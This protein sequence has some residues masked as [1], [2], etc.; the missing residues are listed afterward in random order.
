[1]GSS[2]SNEIM[3]P[4]QG[5]GIT[6]V[7]P[8]SKGSTTI[9]PPHMY[10]REH[11]DGNFNPAVAISLDK[12]PT[13]LV[14]GAGMAGVHAAYELAMRGFKVSVI[15][16][17][18]QVGLG[19]T[20]FAYPVVGEKFRPFVFEKFSWK[21]AV[22]SALFG[23]NSPGGLL[24]EDR[25]STL[26][27]NLKCFGTVRKALRCSTEELDSVFK[28]MSDDSISVIKGMAR[29][30]PSL[31]K[32]AVRIPSTD[33]AGGAMRALPVV[34][35]A[36]TTAAKKQK[37]HH[38]V[39]VVDSS[40][41]NWTLIPTEGSSL[42]TAT[43][44]PLPTIHQGERIVVNPLKWTRTL[45]DVCRNELGVEFHMG[46]DLYNIHTKEHRDGYD[47]V[48]EVIGDEHKG[49]KD[50]YL[51]KKVLTADVYVLAA[52]HGLIAA[53]NHVL[54]EMPLIPV[55]GLAVV[56]P[57]PT[58]TTAPTKLLANDLLRSSGGSA[59]T[60]AAGYVSENG[61][62]HAVPFDRPTFTGNPREGPINEVA[63]CGGSIVT[64]TMNS[65]ITESPSTV[66]KSLQ[67][68]VRAG[69]PVEWKDAIL[70]VAG[71][72]ASSASRSNG[73]QVLQYPRVVTP[74]GLPVV[75]RLGP[76]FN[77]F[78][79]GGFHDNACALVP[80]CAKSL[81]EMVTHPSKQ[82]I[83]HPLSLDRYMP[84]NI[85]LKARPPTPTVEEL[86]EE[87]RRNR[88]SLGYYDHF[89]N[90]MNH[91]VSYPVRSA[92]SSTAFALYQSDLFGS[93]FKDWLYFN[94]ITI[95]QEEEV[96][97]GPIEE[98]R[99]YSD[100]K[101]SANTIASP[102][103]SN[104]LYPFTEGHRVLSASREIVDMPL[105]DEEKRQWKRPQQ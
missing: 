63:V 92:V 100:I 35:E 102:T 44:S 41:E 38:D 70:Q 19:S 23:T 86:I 80:S 101:M 71:P 98:Y 93:S 75:S 22:A 72:G 50:N 7:F 60:L 45:A 66:A 31:A 2:H 10:P 49:A 46:T 62:T 103:A 94:F 64:S 77:A 65:L 84:N 96:R 51:H 82:E 83:A 43:D 3:T 104:P 99:R 27:N 25:S 79:I 12:A 8:A 73:V 36:P 20:A 67:K 29:K 13:A 6:G 89:C 9:L 85:R 11:D 14:V 52:G 15:D 78:V 81:A 58:D 18:L 56:M 40:M 74:D 28:L 5:S 4:Y 1:M 30:H 55:N 37:A 90:A 39:Q 17:N 95:E 48:S 32:C 69:L 105:T 16:S 91:L 88:S 54:G 57:R 68:L 53:L 47:V 76:V 21:A 33:V 87:S 26:L 97:G 24:F 34:D 42:E 61:S 59:L